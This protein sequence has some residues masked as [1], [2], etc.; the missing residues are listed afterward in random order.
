MKSAFS[1]EVK[2]LKEIANG[3]GNDQSEGAQELKEQYKQYIKDIFNL[4]K[5]KINTI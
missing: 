4:L 1:L 2:K 5:I 3:F